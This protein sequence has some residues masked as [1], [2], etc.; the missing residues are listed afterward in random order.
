MLV[1]L[2]KHHTNKGTLSMKRNT[3]IIEIQYS[4]V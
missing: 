3:T 1:F 4:I 2:T